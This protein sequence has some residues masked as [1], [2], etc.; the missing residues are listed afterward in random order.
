MQAF[1][2]NVPIYITC[3]VISELPAYGQ[4]FFF[5]SFLVAK[6]RLASWQENGVPIL[7]FQC[8]STCINQHTSDSWLC[9]AEDLASVRLPLHLSRLDISAKL[10]RIY[11][12]LLLFYLLFF[13]P[14]KATRKASIFWWVGALLLFPLQLQTKEGLI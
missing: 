12:T 11:L 13:F 7:I 5:S 3:I 1:S 10:K 9:Q 6:E 8:F 2:S 14:V 4:A